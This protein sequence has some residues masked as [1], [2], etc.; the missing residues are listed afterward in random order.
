MKSAKEYRNCKFES[1]LPWPAADCAESLILEMKQYLSVREAVLDL[2]GAEISSVQPVTGGDI[3]R[4]YRLTING[5][6]IRNENNLCSE[7]PGCRYR[8]K[9]WFISTVG[10]VSGNILQDLL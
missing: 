10:M 2:F 8:S 6:N 7:D 4:A 9:V 3:N 1:L 5:N